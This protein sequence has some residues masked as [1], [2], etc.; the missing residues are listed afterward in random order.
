MD[1]S[2]YAR[3]IAVL[4]FVIALIAGFAWL[5]RRSG[6]LPT[7]VMKRKAGEAARLTVREVLPLDAKR[8]LVLVQ[9]DDVEHLLLLGAD[10]E[11]VVERGIRPPGA[12]HSAAGTDADSDKDADPGASEGADEGKEA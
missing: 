3:F 8:R 7:A 11:S 2:E 6:L 1:L 9:R 12:D 4:A 5:V 10:S